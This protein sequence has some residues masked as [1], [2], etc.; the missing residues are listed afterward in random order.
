MHDDSDQRHADISGRAG[1]KPGGPEHRLEHE[2]GRRLSIGTG[3]H[4]PG[5]GRFDGPQPPGELQFA[6]YRDPSRERL[7]DDRARRWKTG[8]HDEDVAFG[9]V[10]GEAQLDLDP[11]DI[12]DLGAFAQGGRVIGVDEHDPCTE[13]S[14]RVSARE[15]GDSN[16]RDDSAHRRPVGGAVQ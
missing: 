12:E 3:D 15:P 4:Q 11:D 2:G 9:E 8:R 13:L 10:S 6:P 1:A 7:P 5:S 16:P 14:E